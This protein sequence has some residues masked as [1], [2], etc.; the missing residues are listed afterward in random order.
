[1][2]RAAAALLL[3]VTLVAASTSFARQEVTGE[4]ETPT[5]YVFRDEEDVRA[6]LA[7]VL[8]SGEYRTLDRMKSRGERRRI[9]A[10]EAEVSPWS[11]WL[12]QF[13][14]WLADWLSR[15]DASQDEGRPIPFPELGWMRW[16]VYLVVGAV[17]AA[18]IALIIKA[19]VKGSS[20]KSR[21]ERRG[22]P[23][24]ETRSSSTPPGELAPAEYLS[25]ALSLAKAADYKAAIRQ[26][27]LGA[28]SWAER[29]GLIRHRRGLTNHD[30]LRA[31]SMQPAPH[32]SLTCIV[33]HFEQVYFGR[34][35][36]SEPGF[37]ECLQHYRRAF[38]N[39][40]PAKADSK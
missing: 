38:H 2:T 14:D 36:S 16:V 17:L 19:V 7:R 12:R 29:G 28:M 18:A 21:P 8:S 6:A 39:S 1:M 26:L 30:Y 13:I 32:A 34:R 23:V 22:V 33:T 11:D 4:E 10:E 31:L 25:R 15:S 40:E 37:R 27:L 9:E 3:I 20:S 5:A 24:R 35:T